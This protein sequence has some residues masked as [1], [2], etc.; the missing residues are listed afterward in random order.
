MRVLYDKYG[1]DL[2]KNG[3]PSPDGTF[4]GGYR[5]SGNTNEIFTKFFGTSNPFTVALDQQGK[6]LSP[7]EQ[8]QSMLNKQ[9]VK[10]Y[11]DLYVTVNC[12]LEELFYGCKKHIMFERIELSG[13]ERTEER[14]S[15]QKEIEVKPGM[16][17][18]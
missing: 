16:L 2:L 9:M 1:E 15:I 8:F 3:V 17:Q 13:D 7:I 12:T 14:H 10:K 4:L 11:S 5:F 18:V 6:Q